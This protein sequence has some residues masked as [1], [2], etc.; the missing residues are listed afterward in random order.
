M[1]AQR[2]RRLWSGWLLDQFSV[3]CNLLFI[4]NW[5]PTSEF[6]QYLNKMI[7]SITATVGSKEKEQVFLYLVT[8]LLCVGLY[9]LLNLCLSVLL[10]LCRILCPVLLRVYLIKMTTKGYWMNT[11]DWLCSLSST[12]ICLIVC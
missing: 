5:T 2:K 9:S 10:Y 8:F 6:L 4:R 7:E 12:Y 3:R 1:L 11:G